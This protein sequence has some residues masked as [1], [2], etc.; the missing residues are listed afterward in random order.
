[1]GKQHFAYSMPVF[2]KC[3][4]SYSLHQDIY[5]GLHQI[6]ILKDNDTRVEFGLVCSR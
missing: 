3:A 6:S 1:M 2:E 5:A 4:E